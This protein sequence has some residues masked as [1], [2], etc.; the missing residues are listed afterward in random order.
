MNKEH[1]DYLIN[2]Y[3]PLYETYYD[4]IYNS[5]MPFGFECGDG[6][7][8]IIDNLSYILCSNWIQAK[9]ELDFISSRLGEL[10]YSDSKKSSWN[11]IITLEMINDAKIKL[12]ELVDDVPRAMQVKE[13]F[14]TLRF[15]TG[16]T[17]EEQDGA[18]RMAEAMSAVTC[19]ECGAPGTL[20]GNGWISCKCENHIRK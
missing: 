14:G 10:K 18:I 6:W 15:Y 17:T 16:P 7:F 20:T 1:T 2:T 13:K 3:Q 5:C 4:S 12:A 9:R 19:D 8:N 11:K